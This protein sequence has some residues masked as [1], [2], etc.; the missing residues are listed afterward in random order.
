MI[1][2]ALLVYFQ[3]QEESP[4]TIR[5]FVISALVLAGVAA[6]I[7]P[8]YLAFQVVLMLTAAA[9]SLLWQGRLPLPQAAGFM[10]ALGLT[11]AIVAYSLGFFIAGGQGYGSVGY[12]FLSM[13]LLAPFY[14][15]IFGHYI[16]GASLSRLM[17]FSQ[18]GFNTGN[19]LGVGVIFLGIFLLLLVVLQRKKLPALD[20][21]RVVPLFLCC[22]VLTLMALSAR[23]MIGSATLN[24]D[25]QYLLKRFL[26][27]LRANDRLFWA[28]FYAIL[29][30][31]L[32]APFLLFRRFQAN[33]LLAILLVIQLVDIAPLQNLVH[34][35]VSRR[36]P[37]PLQSPILVPAWFGS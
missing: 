31:V 3:A 12:L 14:P 8:L 11:C 19:Y 18:E 36:P 30:A 32:A 24:L 5:R 22:L 29:T 15:F 7:N 26:G 23:V 27:L 16:T 37:Q 33:L 6:G 35:I 2:A 13:N 9:A 10:A 34:S 4:R 28:P 21:R 1:V 17:P 25:P 20:K